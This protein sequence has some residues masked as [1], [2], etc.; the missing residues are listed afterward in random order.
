MLL[1]KS[2]AFTAIIAFILTAAIEPVASAAATDPRNIRNGHV[3][4]D[5]GYCDQPYVVKTADGN[6]LCV[7]TTGPGGESGKG[8]HIVSTISKDKGRT[9]SPPLDIEPSSG[10]KASWAMPLATPGGRVYVFYTYNDKNIP[11]RSSSMIGSLS[12]KYSDDNG[13]S[14]SKRRYKIPL[15]ITHIDRNNMWQGK[16]QAFWGVDNPVVHGN[17]MYFAFTKIHGSDYTGEYRWSTKGDGFVAHS[18]NIL[19]EKDPAKINWRILPDGDHGI[20]SPD[21][22]NVQEEHNL[23]TLSDG[24]LYCIYRTAIGSPAHS[25]SRD[26]GRTWTRPVKATYTPGGR[27]IKN[28]WANAHI[29]KTAEGRY[30]L[31]Y[32]NSGN[33]DDCKQ[34]RDTLKWLKT[35]EDF[36]EVSKVFPRNPNWLSGGTEVDGKIHWSQPELVLYDP[37]RFTMFSYPDLIQEG[38][39]YWITE[40]NKGIARVHK[41]DS[42]LIEGLWTQGKL[43]AVTKDGLVLDHHHATNPKSSLPIPALPNLTDGGGFSIELSFKTDNTKPGQ[44]IVDT[45]NTKGQGILLGTAADGAVELKL[46]DGKIT[47]TATS[48]PGTI[49]P[50]TL[51]HVVATIDGGPKIISFIIDG[52]FNDGG[53][54]RASGYTWFD[55][56]LANLN[57]NPKATIAPTLQGNLNLLRIYN[58]PLRTSEAVGNYNAAK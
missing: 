10:P 11:G 20:R 28:S 17:H 23:V 50:N 32:T 26:G 12:Y 44:V 58:R 24:S 21:L 39:N 38:D 46:S 49:R 13:R 2:I 25:Y 57:G 8:Q 14:W 18:D 47:A 16:H 52:I 3:I 34:L 43:K 19:S 42:D 33:A 5:E 53:P 27:V 45:R 51:H 56:G 37:R 7:I 48:D 31:W 35:E 22:G 1:K 15:P 41:I 55:P 6:W 9:W 40:T 4:P 29:W 36:K 54:A 30:L